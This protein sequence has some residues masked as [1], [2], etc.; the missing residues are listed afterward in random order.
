MKTFASHALIAAAVGGMVLA[1]AA[2]AASA[3]PG[4]GSCPPPGHEFIS[5]AAKEPGPNSG[6]NGNHWGPTRDGKPASPGQAVV[7]ACLLGF[8]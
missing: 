3:A 6:P 2:S 5:G 1:G 7:G 4:P 8:D